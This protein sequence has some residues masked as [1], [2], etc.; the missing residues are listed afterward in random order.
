MTMQTQEQ[1]ALQQAIEQLYAVFARY[2]LRSVVEGCPHCVYAADNEMLHAAPLRALPRENLEK[3][4]W[5][6]MTTWGKVSDFKHFLPRLLEI[7]VDDDCDFDFEAFGSKF[8]YAEYGAWPEDERLAVESF[9]MAWWRVVLATFPTRNLIIFHLGMFAQFIEDIR[10]FLGVLR[11]TEI[12]SAQR[13]FVQLCLDLTTGN[14]SEPL[15]PPAWWEDRPSQ[16]R[17][18]VDWFFEPLTVAQFD[19]ALQV[20][21]A[22][23]DMND[24]QQWLKECVLSLVRPA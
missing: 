5:K 1:Q 19:R 2:P 3:Y 17:Q 24:F 12:A 22:Y 16:W 7:L 14:G 4:A 15:T 13:H 18:F 9:C 6:T 10:P 20:A 23:G 11:N 21:E 8:H